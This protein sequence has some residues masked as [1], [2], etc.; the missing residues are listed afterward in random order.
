MIAIAAADEN[1]GIGFEGKLLADLPGDRRYFREYTLNKVVVMGRKTLES[2][3][4]GRPL[5]SRVNIVLSRNPAFRADCEVF[6]SFER[7]L[8][9]LAHL[10][11]DAVYIAGGAEIYR[12]FLPYC[13]A[14]LI[15]RIEAKL[16]ADAFFAD[17]DADGAF[18]CVFESAP[19]SENGFV[20]RFTRY[21]RKGAPASAFPQGNRG[22]NG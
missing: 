2:L 13:D 10:D 11:R 18:E 22:G 12:Q 3:P 15:T 6:S 17:L 14:C 1:L 5:P 20:Y 7:C 4:G 21:V 9:R 16:P 19:Q 8:A